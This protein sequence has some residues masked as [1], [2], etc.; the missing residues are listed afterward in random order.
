METMVAGKP[1]RSL[2]LRS[3]EK[4][5]ARTVIRNPPIRKQLEAQNNQIHVWNVRLKRI[6]ISAI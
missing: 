4:E 5:S 3:S 6:N 2:R 1:I